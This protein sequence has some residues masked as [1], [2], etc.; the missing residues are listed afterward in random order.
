MTASA[1]ILLIDDDG[2]N[3]DVLES[4]LHS[5]EYRLVRA[6]TAEDAL[7]LLLNGEFAAI[8]LDIHMP[9]MTGIELA[10]LIKQ[11]EAAPKAIPIMLPHGLLPG[12][13]GY[14]PG[15]RHPGPSTT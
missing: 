9:G 13:P 4:L 10:N 12:G 11:R 15:L 7:L 1:N 3:L 6:M 14:P 2:R 5:A 8:V